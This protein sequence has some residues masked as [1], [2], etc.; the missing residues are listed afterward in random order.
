MALIT[1][2]QLGFTYLAPMQ[3]VFGPRPLDGGAWL[4]II[5]FGVALTL[6]AEIEKAIVRALRR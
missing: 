5:A 1:A 2:L 6:A 3:K 4:A